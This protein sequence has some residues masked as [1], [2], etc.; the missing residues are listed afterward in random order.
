MEKYVLRKQLILLRKNII[1]KEIKSKI[2]F[3]KVIN[4]EE[5]NNSK[6]IAFYKNLESEVDT[7]KMIEYSIKH[8]KT[9]VLPRTE[10][11]ELKFFKID[12]LKKD[13][14]EKSDFGIEEPIEN[15]KKYIEYTDIDLIIV[16]GVGFDIYKN[17]LGFGK[18]YYDRLL[19]G[20]KIKN[21]AICFDDQ[22]LKE[23]TIPTNKYDVKVDKI[24][25]E[26][27]IYI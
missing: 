27:N 19:K 5:Y 14:F 13:L 15:N 26:K 17:R 7:T 21:I 20:R 18:G 10:K 24:I 16:P 1:E 12:S 9:V 3:E 11:N 25:T 8:K 4:T 22:V 23:E 6:V 2:I